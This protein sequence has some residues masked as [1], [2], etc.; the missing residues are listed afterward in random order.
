M[1]IKIVNRQCWVG[2]PSSAPYG[3]ALYAYDVVRMKYILHCVHTTQI[4]DPEWHVLPEKGELKD[5][6]TS[7]KALYPDAEIVCDVDGA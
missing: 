5:F 3:M 1:K 4:E 2:E 6:Y 7:V